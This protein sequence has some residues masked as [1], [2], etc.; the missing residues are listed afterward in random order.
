MA[1][2][3]EP[4]KKDF[5]SGFFA[6]SSVFVQDRHDS[7]IWLQQERRRELRLQSYDTYLTNHVQEIAN[8]SI[9]KIVNR[10]PVDGFSE[11][12]FLSLFKYSFDVDIMKFLVTVID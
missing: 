9:I 8:D 6:S 10:N 3:N 5:I 12:L 11:I 2:L 4:P 1:V 7:Q